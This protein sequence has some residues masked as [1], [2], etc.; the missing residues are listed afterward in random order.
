MRLSATHRKF[1]PIR[2]V[3]GGACLRPRRLAQCCC[4]SPPASSPVIRREHFSVGLNVRR[5]ALRIA[6]AI[7]AVV[8]I[9]LATT[10][11][12]S[13]HQVLRVGTYHG[14][15]GQFR[16][17]QAAVDAARPD[18]WILVGPGDYKTTASRHPRG[19]SSTPAGV[20]IT[21]PDIYIRGMNRNT[22]RRST[23]R[24]RDQAAAATKRWPRTSVPSR[25]GAAQRHDGLEGRR[26]L[27]PEPHGVQLP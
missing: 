7:I 14:I 9:G 27:G 12:A 25:A 18:D 24:S 6:G 22:R 13:A 8:A 26:C 16:S 3:P 21:T 2:T 20:L 19:R 15:P 23:A 1:R 4:A 10:T 5:A 17:I 11:A